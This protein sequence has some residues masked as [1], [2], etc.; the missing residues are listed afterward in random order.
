MKILDKYIIKNFLGT[1]F[2]TEAVILILAMVVDMSEKIE[3]FLRNNAPG[4]EIATYYGNFALYYG[5][6]YMSL[7]VF[8]AA[9]IFTSK[10]AA[11]SEIIA[12]L[13]A[14]VRYE[15]LLRPYI[16][17][18]IFLTVVSLLVNN[19]IIPSSNVQRLAFEDKYVKNKDFSEEYI[20]D[21]HK[22]VGEGQIIYIQE[23]IVGSGSGNKF[24]FETYDSTGLL[25]KKLNADYISYDKDS[26][27]FRLSTFFERE[28][29]PDGTEKL[30]SGY[31][32]DTVFA[33]TPE[34]FV[35]DSRIAEKKNTVELSRLI[36]LEEKRGSPN[37]RVLI[38]ERYKRVALPFSTIILTILAVT[39]CSRKKRGGT[40]INIAV[41]IVLMAAYL[42]MLRV[43]EATAAKGTDSIPLFWVWLPNI[44]FA[45]IAYYTYRNAR[46]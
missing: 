6:M 24:S 23:W 42:F 32:K 1:F 28:I 41:G 21:I 29:H 40:G 36:K 15:R 8:L 22:Q 5:N 18:A 27:R 19:F 26:A 3:P 30:T 45:F 7:V 17:G 10:F 46:K 13:S 11:R 31:T 39:L 44:I 2:V 33:F 9:T 37:T 12:I 20:N 25:V 35:M 38:T 34:D 16:Y 14:G 43:F 4:N